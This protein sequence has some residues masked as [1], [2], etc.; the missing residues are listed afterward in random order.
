MGVNAGEAAGHSDKWWNAVAS[1]K[2]QGPR[3]EC[4]AQWGGEEAVRVC[5]VRAAQRA[6]RG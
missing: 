2:V 3:R 1:G 5:R 6:R 4:D